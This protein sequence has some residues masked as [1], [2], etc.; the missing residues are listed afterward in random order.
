MAALHGA[1]DVADRI[2]W[3]AGADASSTV[4]QLPHTCP[5]GS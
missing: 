4:E 3:I 1:G 5:R 2:A